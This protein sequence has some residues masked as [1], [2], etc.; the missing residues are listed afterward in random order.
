M[1]ILRML[2][3]LIVSLLLI[4][5]Q[6][7]NAKNNIFASEN[8]KIA[9]VAVVM[10]DF[11]HPQMLFIKQGLTDIQNENRDKVNFIFY[12]GKGN[13]AIQTEIINSLISNSNID[14]MVIGLINP[15]SDVVEDIIRKADLRNMPIIMNDVNPETALKLSKG[16]SKVIFLKGKSEEVG[17]LQGKILVDEWNNK[18]M[19]KNKDN[20]LQY[21]MLKGE[22][23]NPVANVREKY[24]VSTINEA[25]IKTQQLALRVVNWN[26]E[27]AKQAIE[28]L[29]LKYDGNIEAIIANDDTIAIG[30]IEAL[31]KY[32]Y[33]KGNK[34][35]YIDVVGATGLQEVKDLI[36]KGFMTGT[37]IINYEAQAEAVYKIAMN[38]LNNESPIKDTNYTISDGFVVLT[39]DYFP[40]TKKNNIS[41]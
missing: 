34:S 22:T 36:D 11:Q 13:L 21:V 1:K 14:L 39:V 8:I 41:S 5:M 28:A 30:A 3:I 24:S 20:I 17:I 23:N 40:Y 27:I 9:N 35:K 26:K 16:Y 12:D 2:F 15:Q 25:G 19:D 6:T 10:N 4:I 29:L 38:L 18:G 37:A 33:N 32:G 31:Q 7:S